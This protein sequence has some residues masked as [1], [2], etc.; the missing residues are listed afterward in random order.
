LTQTRRKNVMSTATNG[1]DRQDL[2]TPYVA[3]R[4]VEPPVDVLESAD[5]VLLVAD[6]PGASVE[7]VD[8]RVENDT[9][10]LEA[11]RP[12]A[13]QDAAPALTREYEE[14]DFA[15]SFRIPAGIDTAN[16]TAEAKNGTVVVRLPKAAAAKTR[17]V[18]VRAS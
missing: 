10:T 4:T 6:V 17:K 16:I 18:D 9:L 11:K 3:R 12:S 7:T 13:S 2:P 15:R 5:N 1:H 8:V 14:V